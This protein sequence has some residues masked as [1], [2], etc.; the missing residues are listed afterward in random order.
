MAV[1]TTISILFVESEQAPAVRVKLVFGVTL[2][3]LAIKPVIYGAVFLE[4]GIGVLIPTK[5]VIFI[6][7]TKHDM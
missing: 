1:D 3:K 5:K 2:L 6:T 4:R 7:S